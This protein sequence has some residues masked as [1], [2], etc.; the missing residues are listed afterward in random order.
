MSAELFNSKKCDN[1]RGQLSWKVGELKSMCET[2][3]I[4]FKSNNTK[5]ELCQK[6]ARYF[7]GI[8]NV[9]S[10]SSSP[11]ASLSSIPLPIDTSNVNQIDIIDS[12]TQKKCKD[13]RGPD[14]WTVKQLQDMCKA[15]KIPINSR[16]MKNDYCLAIKK[17]IKD[18]T[19]ISPI[20]PQGSISK[21][22]SVQ[23]A[24]INPVFPQD[25]SIPT[26]QS[27]IKPVIDTAQNIFTYKQK[28]II[29]AMGS[30]KLPIPEGLV[31]MKDRNI[32]Q[33]KEQFI[34]KNCSKWSIG[35]LK[36]ICFK[37]GLN[38]TVKDDKKSICFKIENFLFGGKERKVDTSFMK[39]YNMGSIQNIFNVNEC[40]NEILPNKYTIDELIDVGKILNIK[41]DKSTPKN[42]MCQIIGDTIKNANVN[43]LVA[44][45]QKSGQ[46]DDM[47]S[48]IT[49][50]LELPIID[51][52]ENDL[53]SVTDDLVR[54]SLI[55]SPQKTDPVIE[56][57]EEVSKSLLDGLIE[58]VKEQSNSF[59][60]EDVPESEVVREEQKFL[61]SLNQ[62]EEEP[63]DKEIA[64]IQSPKVNNP[65]FNGEDDE[66]DDQIM[67][68]NLAALDSSSDEE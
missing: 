56:E 10:E 59:D 13:A 51:T 64:K 37:L 63:L 53:D 40:Q 65:Y 7:R 43:D 30:N 29:K 31:S 46:D 9:N 17:Y 22:S 25:I 32:Q 38:Y 19:G 33:I 58:D 1:T 39:N 16:M 28:Q 54:K 5:P 60:T 44:A 35:E 4:P 45:M 11:V 42:Q 8:S 18:T 27:T 6:I 49:V 24:V 2:L 48:E 52:Y 26:F 3:K 36:E 21:L 62:S 15:V 20:T 57:T 68:I 67:K 34:D 50:D 66:D 47:R 23:P 14:S 41:L 12:F 55:M 61:D